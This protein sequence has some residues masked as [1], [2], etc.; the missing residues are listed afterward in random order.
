M[1]GWVGSEAGEGRASG[2]EIVRLLGVYI[3]GS[4]REREGGDGDRASH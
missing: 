2:L 1:L 3:R 4:K